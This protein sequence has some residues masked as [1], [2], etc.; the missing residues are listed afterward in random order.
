[1]G[2]D[3]GVEALQCASQCA[4]MYKE[5]GDSRGEAQALVTVAHANHLLSKEDESADALTK[6]MSIFQEVG[7]EGG[8]AI[9]MQAMQQ[10]MGVPQYFGAPAAQLDA[11]VTQQ[12]PVDINKAP[13]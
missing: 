12:P 11:P 2:N 4:E 10:F 6:A 5:L 8:Q 13:K 3:K 9:V 1:M 7:D